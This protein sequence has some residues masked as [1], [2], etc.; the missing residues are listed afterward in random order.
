[1]H[2]ENGIIDTNKYKAK[3]SNLNILSI[4][5]EKLKFTSDITIES[6]I[7]NKLSS[8]FLIKNA[9]KVKIQNIEIKNSYKEI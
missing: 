8:I 7:I 1:M 5:L 2:H 3:F 6:V 4:Q 9:N